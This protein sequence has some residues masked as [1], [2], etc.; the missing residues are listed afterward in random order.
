VFSLRKKYSEEQKTI[1]SQRGERGRRILNCH[2]FGTFLALLMAFAYYK[3]LSPASKRPN[4][5]KPVCLTDFLRAFEKL[6]GEV[7]ETN[8]IYVLLSNGHWKFFKYLRKA[9]NLCA[10]CLKPVTIQ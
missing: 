10:K 4:L 7:V 5:T 9:H 6:M 8:T 1:E 3:E 2:G